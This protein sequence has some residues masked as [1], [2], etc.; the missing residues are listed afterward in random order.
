MK[1]L[2]RNVR[3]AGQRPGSPQPTY[4]T[5]PRG[6]LHLLSLKCKWRNHPISMSV[7][8]NG[9]SNPGETEVDALQSSYLASGSSVHAEAL[10]LQRNLDFELMG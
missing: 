2:R 5:E 4:A 6:H 3:F 10:S 1:S 8:L 9:T 7:N